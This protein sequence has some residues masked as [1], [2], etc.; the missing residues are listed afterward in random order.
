TA[1]ST[2]PDTVH[3]YTNDSTYIV[4]M[5]LSNRCDVDTV[6]TD[7]ITVFTIPEN[8]MVPSDTALCDSNGLTLN[9]WDVDR[10]DLRYYWST[11]DTTRSVTFLAPAIVDVAIS[12]TD[13]CASDT[14]TVFIG[15]GR[16]NLELGADRSF[17][18]TDT[19]PDLDV[20][21]AGADFT[22][23]VDGIEVGTTQTQPVNTLTAGTFLYKVE[24]IDPI[25]GCLGEDSVSIT[26]QPVATITTN[27]ITPSSCGNAD[28]SIDFSINTA[29]TFS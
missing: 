10:P 1:P 5:T 4:R 22:W 17:C 16:P 11:G 25:T 14:V 12:N 19:V 7:T 27:N 21:N 13:G 23:T 9:A 29:G 26:I 3:T 6:F 28:G 15:D 18:Q 20:G 8:P 2:D 24:I